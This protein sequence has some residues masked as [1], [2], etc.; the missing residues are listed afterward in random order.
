MQR[1]LPMTVLHPVVNYTVA[2]RR[3]VGLCEPHRS[4]ADWYL[5][6]LTFHRNR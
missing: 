3:L 6:E 2:D 5:D 4:F 1:D